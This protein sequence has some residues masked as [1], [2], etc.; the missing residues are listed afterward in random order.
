MCF[1]ATMD[2]YYEVSLE[3][4]LT[5]TNNEEL[6]T[7]DSSESKITAVVK[8]EYPMKARSKA[9]CLDER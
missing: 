6:R 7:K 9:L 1:A 8:I 3:I 5:K 4:T 2:L